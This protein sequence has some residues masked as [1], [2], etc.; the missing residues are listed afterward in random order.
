MPLKKFLAPRADNPIE[1]DSTVTSRTM[2]GRQDRIIQARLNLP[3]H[4]EG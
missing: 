3:D 1:L 2:P 4:G